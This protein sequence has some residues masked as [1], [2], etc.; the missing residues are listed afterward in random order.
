ME[1]TI[2]PSVMP[3]EIPD[4]VHYKTG[5]GIISLVPPS[6]VT[7]DRYEIYCIEGNLFEGTE[8]YNTLELTENRIKELLED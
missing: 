5:K 2:M 6:F 4:A 7:S 1:K 8:Q 3:D